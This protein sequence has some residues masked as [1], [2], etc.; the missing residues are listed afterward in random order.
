MWNEASAVAFQVL[1][2]LHLLA[3]TAV[4]WIVGADAIPYVYALIAMIGLASWIALLY[5]GSLGVHLEGSTWTSWRRMVPVLVLVV[6]LA[7]GLIRAQVDDVEVDDW[8]T[9]AGMVTGAAFALGVFAAAARFA[10][11][12]TRGDDED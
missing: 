7:A 6:L 3:A 1:I 9:I 4:V 5:A 11:K 2:W 10:R 12:W 8:S